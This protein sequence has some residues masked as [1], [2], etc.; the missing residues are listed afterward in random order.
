MI[1]EI[2]KPVV[3]RIPKEIKKISY[4]FVEKEK[5]IPQVTTQEQI[6]G[7]PRVE[8]VNCTK[9][10]VKTETQSIPKEVFVP[11]IKVEEREVEVP[12][13]EKVE[14]VVEKPE[15][16]IREIVREVPKFITEVIER[17]VP[18]PEIQYVEKL[19]EIPTMEVRERMVEVPEIE[20]REVVRKVPRPI[21]H[22]VDK[23]V[24]KPDI[25][26]AP[27]MVEVPCLLSEERP[28]EVPQALVAEAVTKVPKP[29]VEV[30]DKEFPKVQI[31][32]LE[33]IVDVPQVLRVENPVETESVNTV[34]Q[35]RQVLK[36][37]TQYVA[38][39][40]PK[41]Q[42][43]E[44]ETIQ[45]VP[46]VLQRE[47]EFIVPQVYQ[48][49]QVRQQL[50]LSLRQQSQIPRINMNGMDSLADS[51]MLQ[52]PDSSFDSS[53]EA[54]TRTMSEAPSSPDPVKFSRPS[55]LGSRS[56][57]AE[58]LITRITSSVRAGQVILPVES[59][60]GFEV[61]QLVI[62]DRWSPQEEVGEIA[63]LKGS[64]VLS[65]PVQFD[66]ALGA[67]VSS[68]TEAKARAVAASAGNSNS[69]INEAIQA[70]P[71]A[72]SVTEV[73]QF[74]TASRVTQYFQS[75]PAMRAAPPSPLRSCNSASRA[76]RSL[77]DSPLVQAIRSSRSTSPMERARQST[78]FTG[79]SRMV[80]PEE[81]PVRAAT[82]LTASARAGQVMLS[83]ASQS[84]FQSGQQIVIDQG[85]SQQEVCEI[86][87]IGG[88]IK[89]TEPLQFDH[90]EGTDVSLFV[91]QAFPVWPGPSR[92]QGSGAITPQII[93]A[94]TKS[95]APLLINSA[96]ATL[97][98]KSVSTAGM[99]STQAL[100]PPSP[101]PMGSIRRA[102]P[103][104]SASRS[105]SPQR[106]VTTVSAL[107]SA[108][109]QRL[110]SSGTML[111]A[112]PLANR[113]AMLTSM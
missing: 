73:G 60:D 104:R 92:S 41:M 53:A 33:K 8:V 109:Q 4:C 97:T 96:V 100:R 64:I 20:I 101:L 19:V 94:S 51:A 55:A 80:K 98:G 24:P 11:E 107:S 77:T 36:P 102:G 31:E 42:L 3:A 52:P 29:S 79:P 113:Y 82:M 39:N 95:P 68:M 75:A 108:T 37:S 49:E 85:S 57:A 105:A 65:L 89:L 27:K 74:G 76:G 47:T 34:D 70:T 63:G 78:S 5:E 110:L 13:F 87:G 28:V 91:Q 22:Y 26:Y 90:S 81:A 43:Q 59:D 83:V 88:L 72:S 66:H 106:S 44:I 48:V 10:V 69:F 86:A 23:F 67:S 35:V 62:I 1:K 12:S 15:I 40:V 25:Q 112:M 18:K 93:A 16:E 30:V 71:A 46:I 50:P 61:G 99:D 32:A 21:V 9:E 6:V 54:E 111:R 38:K 14:R 58:A 2:A 84:G 45:E 56:P 7:V 103:S 17:R